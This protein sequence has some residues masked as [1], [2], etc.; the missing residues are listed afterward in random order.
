MGTGDPSFMLKKRIF[1]FFIDGINHNDELLKFYFQNC[2]LNKD[3]IMYNNIKSIMNSLN[4][5]IDSVLHPSSKLII[6]KHKIYND[7][8][9]NIIKEIIEW[10]DFN[11]VIDMTRDDIL[12]ILEYLCT[13]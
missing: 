3:T 12:Y 4:C 11:V 10:K 6:K 5:S 9:V 1:N 8:R 2:F 13:A 7:W